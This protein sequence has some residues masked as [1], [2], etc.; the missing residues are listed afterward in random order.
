MAQ[1]K[2]IQ[3]NVR[4]WSTNKHS[5]DHAYQQEYP[6][7][8][9]I[10]SHGAI[11]NENIKIFNYNIHQINTLNEIN[12]GVAVGVRRDIK[13]KLIDNFESD[14]LGITIETS[15]GPVHIITAYIPPRCP[16][17]HYPDFYKILKHKEPVYILGDL[18]ARHE[19][20][21]HQNRNIRGE[22]LAKLI[23]RGHA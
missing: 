22:L 18:N 20:L 21:G 17:L 5:L 3:H 11:D 4:K 12:N 1:I 9:L 8:I 6:E 19:I 2:I 15:L 16:Y 10:N 13:Y 7:I 14:M 23:N